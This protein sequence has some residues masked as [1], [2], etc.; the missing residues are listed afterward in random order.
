MLRNLLTI[1]VFGLA[2]SASLL[3]A[4]CATS[5]ESNRPNALIG[6]EYVRPAP[7]TPKDQLTPQ[8]VAQYTDQKGRFHPEWVGEPGR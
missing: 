8:Q 6:S 5:E 7:G 3:A 2:T 1:A 4:G